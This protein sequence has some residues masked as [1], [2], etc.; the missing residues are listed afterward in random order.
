DNG[1]GT[2]TNTVTGL[3]AGLSYDST[4]NT[5]TGT[6]TQLGN[7]TVTVTSVDQAGNSSSSTFTINVVDT[8]NPVIDIGNQSNQVFTPINNVTINTSDN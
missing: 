2:V 8:T 1:T 6:P 7:N 5:I 4:S 3:P